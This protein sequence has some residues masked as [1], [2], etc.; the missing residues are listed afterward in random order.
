MDGLSR[1]R[2]SPETQ[3]NQL[4]ILL[5]ASHVLNS[6]LDLDSLTQIIVETATRVTGS[7][8]ASI[9]LLDETTQEFHVQAATGAGL[10]GQR[11]IVGAR[12][13]SLAGRVANQ[14]E[15]LLINNVQ[16]DPGYTR[17]D[18]PTGLVARSFLGMPLRVKDETIG[19]LEV[20]N[21]NDPGLFTEYDIQAMETLAAQAAAAIKN[22]RLCADLQHQV[23][24]LQ[25]TQAQLVQREKLAAVSDLAAGVAH[26]LNN[27][28][29]TII[30]FAELIQLNNP[31]EQFRQD[32]NKI[33]NQARRAAR[34]VHDLLDFARQRPHQQTWIQVHDVL[35]SALNLLS[36]ELRSHNVVYSTDFAP[37]L[38]LTMADP[39]ELQQVF[40]NL[41]QNARHAMST[42]N[43]GGQLII[44]TQPGSKLFRSTDQKAGNKGEKKKA[45]QITFK[46]D[47]PGIP[48]D[49]LPRIFDPFFTTKQPGEGTGLGL[50]VCHGI[51]SDHGG[52]IWAKSKLGQG[53]TFCIELPII[54]L[55]EP[56][57]ATL[58]EWPILSKA[59]SSPTESEVTA[60][61]LVID[62]DVYLLELLTRTLQSAGYNVDTTSQAQTAL[63]KLDE[64]NYD[65]IVCEVNMPEMKG[66]ELFE[67]AQKQIPNLAKQLIFISGNSLN[68]ITYQFLDESGIPYLAKPFKPNELIEK[69]HQI[70]E[71]Q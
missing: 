70:L 39:Q 45:I 12:E 68:S 15:P 35:N 62:N 16:E 58:T 59:G 28:L 11:S 57:W 60:H 42:A 26:E 22:A 50:S 8:S 69:V 23:E 67:Q 13:D 38:P 34:I 4:R 32:L 36:Y 19:V 43:N 7:E 44:T 21:K 46:D 31:D 64:S 14:N 71:A 17:A 55:D 41:L 65:L 2:T 53:C 20:I 37:D 40:I 61:I 66:L 25:K 10:V 5:D 9:L 49:H 30:G 56:H 24:T 27:P 47:G 48:P 29:T 52:Y 3:I 54:E 1:N 63:T 51:I 6:T 33:T 18:D